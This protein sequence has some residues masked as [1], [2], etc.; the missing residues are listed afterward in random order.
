M[1]K[2]AKPEFLDGGPVFG[3]EFDWL[4]DEPELKG[5]PKDREAIGSTAERKENG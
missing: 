4:K 1:E 3:D 2:P 5:E